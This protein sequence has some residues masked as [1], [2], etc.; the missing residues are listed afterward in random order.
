MKINGKDLN[1][2]DHF[3][4]EQHVENYVYFWSA[5][6]CKIEV[7]NG[8]VQ[9]TGIVD[10]VLTFKDGKPYG[11]KKHDEKDLLITVIGKEILIGVEKNERMDQR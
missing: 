1:V 5:T 6:V 10:A 3:I 11:F 7:E 4:E 2:G 8:Q 9:I